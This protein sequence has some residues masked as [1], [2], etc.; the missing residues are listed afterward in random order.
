[1]NLRVVLIEDDVALR[2]QI[3]DE[4]DRSGCRVDTASDEVLVAYQRRFRTMGACDLTAPL[5]VGIHHGSQTHVGSALEGREVLQ[6]RDGATADDGKR[7][8]LHALLSASRKGM[9]ETAD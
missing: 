4:L 9:A 2:N 6:E 3:A 8:L 5:D 1:M 7:Q